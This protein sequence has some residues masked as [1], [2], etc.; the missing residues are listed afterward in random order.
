[1]SEFAYCIEDCQE[2]FSE[3]YV[4]AIAAVAGFGFQVVNKDRNSID[5]D[6]KQRISESHCPEF[7]MLRIQLKCTYAHNPINGVLRFPLSVKNYNE[8]RPMKL[9]IPRIL[10]V[11]HVPNPPKTNWLQ[12]NLD[13]LLLRYEAFWISL[14]GAPETKNEESITVSLENKFTTE[15][16]VSLMDGIANGNTP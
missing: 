7:E 1:M 14:K 4:S 12:H 16:L 10:V 5:A 9:V 13:H 6:I 15:S 11:V 8:L 2:F 3:A